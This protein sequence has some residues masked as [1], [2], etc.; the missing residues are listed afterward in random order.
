MRVGEQKKEERKRRKELR[1]VEKTD[2]RVKGL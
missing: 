2:E 1:R